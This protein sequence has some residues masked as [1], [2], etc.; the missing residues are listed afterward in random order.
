MTRTSE[1]VLAGMREH[2][3]KGR[4]SL[5]EFLGG[6]VE[7]ASRGTRVITEDGVEYLDCGG[8]GVFILG[9]AHP[10]VLAAVR[11]QL[12]THPLATRVFAEPALVEAARALARVTPDGLEYVHFVTSGAEATEAALKIARSQGR[13]RLISMRGGYHGK[14]LG[15]LSVTAREAYQDPFRPLLPDVTHVPFGDAAAL[16]I[17]LAQDNGPA[18]VIVEPVQAEGGVAIPPDGYLRA[19]ETLCRRNGAMFVLDEIQTG[20]GRLGTWWG[21]DRDGVVPDVLLVGKGLSGGVVPVAAAVA[22]PAAYDVLNRDPTLHTSTFAGAPLAMAA[23][24]A[25][26]E[27]IADERIV[28]RSQ[29]LGAEL[30]DALRALPSLA[31]GGIVTAVRGRGL[32]IGLELAAP[33]LAAELMIELIAR[34]VIVNHSLNNHSVVRLTPAAVM[35]GEDV[36]W[37]LEAVDESAK[38]ISRRPLAQAA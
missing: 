27:T 11:A 16:D 30:L 33:H 32:L 10:R 17:A 7:V 35:S 8:Y 13:R 23:A 9:H 25:A 5:T 15:A 22:T 38:A 36:S 31:P 28:Q 21:A 4:A 26:V 24:R 2:V 14:T 12:D 19:V 29:R 6:H 34:R 1:S 18:C 37:L 3:S 20:L